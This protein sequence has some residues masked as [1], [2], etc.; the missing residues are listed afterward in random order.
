MPKVLDGQVDLLEELGVQVT[1]VEK[2]KRK[3]GREVS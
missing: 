3:K 1:L 2:T